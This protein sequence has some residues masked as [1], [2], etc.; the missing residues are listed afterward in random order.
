MNNLK[1][2]A[3]NMLGNNPNW[4]SNPVLQNAVTLAQNGDEKGLEQLARNLA[5]ESGV[6]INQILRMFQ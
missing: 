5:K 6:D 1:T 4:R 3:M 2:M